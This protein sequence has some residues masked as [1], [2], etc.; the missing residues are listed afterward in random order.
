MKSATVFT[1][2]IRQS[3]LQIRDE[4]KW[5]KPLSLSLKRIIHEKQTRSVSTRPFNESQLLLSRIHYK[6]LNVLWF[7]VSPITWQTQVR[8]IYD[9]RA[10][11]FWPYAFQLRFHA[12]AQL[13][14]WDIK[15]ISAWHLRRK[16]ASI[17]KKWIEF[18]G[19]QGRVAC[20]PICTLDSLMASIK[21][22]DLRRAPQNDTYI[23]NFGRRITVRRVTSAA[24]DSPCSFRFIARS[25]HIFA[26]RK[27]STLYGWLIIFHLWSP[28]TSGELETAQQRDWTTF[29]R[30]RRPA[31]FFLLQRRRR[32]PKNLNVALCRRRR[33]FVLRSMIN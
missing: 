27:M 30:A 22:G 11:T 9:E 32:A 16:Q 19:L 13:W 2:N 25:S 12:K 24:W 8:I 29:T 15:T 23:T 10:T 4:I 5:G 7:S 18:P 14:R 26:R 28:S 33:L 20:D 1:G 31:E 6:I 21:S 17:S 3:A